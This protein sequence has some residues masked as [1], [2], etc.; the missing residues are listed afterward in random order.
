MFS[1]PRVFATPAEPVL[2]FEVQ[3]RS[4][5]AAP[6][7]PIQ[8][9]ILV[10][11]FLERF[12]NNEMATSD[13]GGK[14]RLIQVACAVGFPGFVMALYLYPMYHLPRGHRPYWAQVSDHYFYV[15]YSLVALGVVTIFEWDFFFPDLLDVFVLSTLPIKGH[16]LFRARIAAVALFVVG[17]LFDSNFLAPLVLPAATEPSNLARLLAAHVL[18]VALSGIFSAALVLALQGMLLGI[19]GGRAFRKVSLLLQGLSITALLIIL[20]LSPILAGALRELMRER[21]TAALCFPPFWFL[22]LYQRVLE[23]AGAPLLF[24][25]LA[26]IG[27]TATALAVAL[28]VFCYPFAYWR[29]T[30]ELVVGSDKGHTHP[31]IVRPVNQWLNATLLRSPIHRAI[32]NFISQTLLRVQRYRIYLVMYGGL[33]LALIAAS[34]LRLRSSHVAIHI[35]VSPDGLR[36]AIPIV[37][38]WTVAGLRTSFQS[39][40]D[41]RGAWIFRVTRGR[42]GL[43]QLIAT[44]R[45]VFL[46][47]VILSLGTMASMHAIT[48]I[49]F[50]GWRVNVVQGLVAVGLSLLLTDIFFLTVR[51][52]P[53]T[54]TRP[55]PATHLAVVLVQYLGVFPIL[56]FLTLSAENWMQASMTRVVFAAVMIAALHLGMEL[57]HRRIVAEYS[58]QAELDEDQEEFPQTLGLRF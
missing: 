3:A 42:P 57:L 45:W 53:F 51:T 48:P 28:A 38:F 44:K 12:F 33:G 23:G 46:W 7:E 9:Q 34:T 18:A 37:A 55:K 56:I 22:G 54:G 40:T 29:K 50:K 49:D 17:F 14:S 58:N 26:R 15:V 2:S 13:D 39:P 52:I 27:G 24:G 1:R 47:A 32:W 21:S 43:G 19:L 8:F 11:H 25:Q 35:G 36:A 41:Q 20:L 5:R 10:R 31:W 6:E 16:R 30:R 4:P